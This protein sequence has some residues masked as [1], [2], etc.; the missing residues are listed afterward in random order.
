M[1]KM[2][3]KALIIIVIIL[4]IGFLIKRKLP[5]WI[6]GIGEGFVTKK[7]LQLD[8]T[9]YKVLNDLL[10]PSKGSLDVTQIDHIVVSN[11]GIFCIETKSYQGWIFGN[12]NQEYW[13]QVIY[14]YKKRF[15]NPLRQNYAHVKAI[16]ELV[17]PRYHEVQIISLVAFPDADKLKISG[18]DFVGYARDVVRKIQSFVNPI[19][20]DSERDEIYKILINANIQ[21]KEVRKLHDK[22]V[23]KLK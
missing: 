4:V 2:F 8:P 21:D 11:Y 6:G 5:F 13:T 3:E 19:I 20:T 1:N 7:L 23:K 15:Y 9:H 18:T 14:H 10:L 16:E 12:A 22:G 17:M